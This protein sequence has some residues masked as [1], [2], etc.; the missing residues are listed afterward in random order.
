MI[1]KQGPT[2]TTKRIKAQLLLSDV[3]YV[4]CLTICTILQLNKFEIYL[5]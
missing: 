1:V 2:L 4:I 3:S 5:F